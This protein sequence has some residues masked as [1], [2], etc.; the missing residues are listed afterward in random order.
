MERNPNQDLQQNSLQ[1][2]KGTGSQAAHWDDEP[3]GNKK[4]TTPLNKL[5]E[6]P[7]EHIRLEK[8]AKSRKKG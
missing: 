4:K 5:G 1:N 8:S 2:N 6:S 3:K 7:N